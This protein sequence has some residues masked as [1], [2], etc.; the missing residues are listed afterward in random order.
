VLELIGSGGQGEVYKA[1]DTR[2]GRNVAIKILPEHLSGRPELRE[3]FERE[4]RVIAAL[5]HPNICTIYDVGSQDGV[6]YIVMEYL[7]GQTLAAR[8]ERGPLP[9]PE[10]LKIAVEM[11]DALDKAHRL[12][13]THRDVKT[14]NIMLTKTGSKLLDFGLAKLAPARSVSAQ[15]P[16]SEQPTAKGESVLTAEG[17]ILGTLQYMSPEQLE[18]QEADARS[19]TRGLS[20]DSCFRSIRSIRKIESRL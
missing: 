13:I 19:F 10:A 11:I 20:L 3:R 9:L 6:D 7:E 2:L 5:N 8:L 1:R 4:A 18:G 15:V 14:G 17:T 12:G 16:L